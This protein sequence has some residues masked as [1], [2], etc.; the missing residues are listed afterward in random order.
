MTPPE[1]NLVHRVGEPTLY[2]R[3]GHPNLYDPKQVARV[4]IVFEPH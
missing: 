1:K 4:P 3:D 2:E